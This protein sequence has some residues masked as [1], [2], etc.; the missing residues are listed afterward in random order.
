MRMIVRVTGQG[1]ITIPKEF[2]KKHDI[3]EG[4]S[5]LME[6]EDGKTVIR[7][8]EKLEN[9]GGVD[10]MFGTPQ[11]LKAKVEELRMEYR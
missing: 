9:L 10:S 8:I 7:K 6:D 4:D 3:Q 1:G 11:Q 5:L 2:R